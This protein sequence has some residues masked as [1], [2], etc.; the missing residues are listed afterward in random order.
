MLRRPPL[1]IGRHHGFADLLGTHTGKSKTLRPV[2]TGGLTNDPLT[3]KS[4]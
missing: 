2:R 3:K 4:G 1:P